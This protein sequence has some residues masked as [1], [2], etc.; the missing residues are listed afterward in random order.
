[1]LTPS[2]SMTAQGRTSSSR[3]GMA[4]TGGT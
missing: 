4:L 3:R 1:M 2:W